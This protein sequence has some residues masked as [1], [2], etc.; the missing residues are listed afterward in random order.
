MIYKQVKL[1]HEHFGLKYTGKPRHLSFE[2]KAFYIEALKEEVSEYEEATGLE[3]EYDALL[4]LMVFTVGAM[5]RHGFPESGIKEVVASNMKKI[6][7]PNKNKRNDFE[8]DL[9][10]PRGWKAPNLTRYVL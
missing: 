5:L 6:L 8:L 10:K 2:E 7:G 1:Q 9:I 3:D 4:D